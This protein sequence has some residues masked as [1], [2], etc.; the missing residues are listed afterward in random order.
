MENKSL[1]PYRPLLI[2]GCQRSGTTLLASMLGRH[3]EINML[4]ES[5]T[6][7]V[8][9]LMGKKYQGNK[10]CVWRQIRLNKRASKWGHLINRLI[11]FHFVGNKYQ[12]V[13][14]YPNS[15]LSINDYINAEAV[16]ITIRRDNEFIHKSMITRTPL[17]HKQATIELNNAN[18]ILD[19][20]S[21]KA[22]EIQYEQLVNEPV[23]VMQNLCKYLGLAYEPKMLEGPKYNIIYPND[24]IVAHKK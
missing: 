10:L 13:R 17:S 19:K 4:F 7:D 8:F 9:N 24:G 11:N 6:K 3:S 14:K 1:K 22:F 5:T 15:Q 16:I 18:R 2:L 20:I 21:A 12:H 23:T